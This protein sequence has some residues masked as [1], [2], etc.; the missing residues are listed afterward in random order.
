MPLVGQNVFKSSVTEYDAQTPVVYTVYNEVHQD[1]LNNTVFLKALADAIDSEIQAAREGKASLL[2]N[3]QS[4]RLALQSGSANFG[5][6]AGTT[7]THNLGTTNFRVSI[8][9][10]ANPDGYLGEIWVVKSS[11]TMTVFNSGDF[12]GA[13]DYQIFK[14]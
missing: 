3:L 6:P 11:N 10:T 9:P 13:F 2:A 12:R 1:L 7:I 5:G 14:N 4:I 8:T